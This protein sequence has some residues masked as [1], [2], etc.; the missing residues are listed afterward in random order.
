MKHY[1]HTLVTSER[2]SHSTC[3]GCG[4][5]DNYLIEV[6]ISVN[7]D[8]EG[9]HRDEYDLCEGCLIERADALAAAGSHAALVNN[10]GDHP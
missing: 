9:G 5:H 7:E 6:I 10:P 3:D 2:Y 1:T 8:G 4:Q